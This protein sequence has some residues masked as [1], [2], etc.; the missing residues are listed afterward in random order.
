MSA[1]A[2]SLSALAS[3]AL[4]DPGVCPAGVLG[5]AVAPPPSS[6]SSEHARKRPG[7]ASHAVVRCATCADLLSFAVKRSKPARSSAGS[8]AAIS[9]ADEAATARGSARSIA[10]S[11]RCFASAPAAAVACSWKPHARSQTYVS[12]AVRTEVR[13]RDDGAAHPT[14]GLKVPRTRGLS[15]RITMALVC[16]ASPCRCSF[17]SAVSP[18]HAASFACSDRLGMH[19]TATKA[20]ATPRSSPY[21]WSRSGSCPSEWATSQ[22]TVVAV[23][24]SCSASGCA[25]WVAAAVLE[26][27]S[28]AR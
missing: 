11:S 25:S 8:A 14:G 17:M 22:R 2:A 23:A 24:L 13:S 10:R 27:A 1:A 6:A 18:S 16:D 3:F 21:P 15:R 4:A 7:A 26:S 20:S 12:A 19:R 28:H 5:A 9:A